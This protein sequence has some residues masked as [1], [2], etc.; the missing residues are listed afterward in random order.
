MLL[1]INWPIA[2]QCYQLTKKELEP[3]T[4]KYKFNI[5]DVTIAFTEVDIPLLIKVY[6]GRTQSK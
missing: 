4:F 5:L 6:V 1:F 2:L 3:P